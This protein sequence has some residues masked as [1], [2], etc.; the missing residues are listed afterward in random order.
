MSTPEE[1]G[2]GLIR[3][4][5]GVDHARRKNV[6]TAVSHCVVSASRET[7]YSP[8]RKREM[9]DVWTCCCCLL[10]LGLE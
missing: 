4:C 10:L 6:Q 8:Q 2:L 1:L 7:S 5:I 3:L 9:L